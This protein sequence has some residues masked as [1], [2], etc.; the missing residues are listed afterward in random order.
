MRIILAFIACSLCLQANNCGGNGGNGG[1]GGSN[2]GT[3]GTSGTGGSGGPGGTG[4][5]GGTSG[6]GGAAGNGLP[7]HGAGSIPLLGPQS[8]FYETMTPQTTYKAYK[9]CPAAVR[10]SH[11]TN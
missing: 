4:S 3:S 1:N 5:T 10:P 2:G 7:A 6:T 11:T 8:D 9:N